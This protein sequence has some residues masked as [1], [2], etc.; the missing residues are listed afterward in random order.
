MTAKTVLIFTVIVAVIAVLAIVMNIRA[1]VKGK[2][3]FTK[4]RTVGT[5]L[6]SV[7]LIIVVA[8]NTAIY[9]FN[10]IIDIYF[11]KINMDSPEIKQARDDAKNLTEE[12]ESEGIVLLKNENNALPIQGKINLFGYSSLSVAYG[13]TG[14]GAGDES[15][16]ID[17]YTG[18]Q[19][20]GFETNDELKSFYEERLTEKTGT[21]IFHLTGGDYNNYEPSA[22]EFTDDIINNA[23]NF[24][25][26]AVVVFSRSGGEGGD[27]PTDMDGKEGGTAGKHYLELTDNERAMLDIAEENFD[28]VVVL[29]NSGNPM[30]LGFLE[31]EQIDAALWVGNPGSTG[32]NAIGSVLCGDTNPSGRLADTYAY[33]VTANPAY[34]NSGDFEYPN[35]DSIVQTQWFELEHYLYLDY[36]ENIYVG[37]R[38]YETRWVDNETGKCDEVAYHKAVQYPFGY[39]LSYTDFTQKIT[40]FE[41][42]GTTVKMDVTVTNTGDVSGKDV[43][44]IY[45]TAPYYVGGIE[46]AHV[47]LIDYGKTQV[48]EPGKSETVSFE[49]PVEDLASY[50]W[51]GIK[52]DGGAYVLEAGNYEIKVMNNAHDVLDSKNFDVKEDIIY[53]EANDG[54]RG[55]DVT[56]A[57]NHFDN[58]SNGNSITYVSRADWEG[59]DVT[60]RPEWKDASEEIIDALENPK[61]PVNDSD[62]PI[63]FAKNGLT[64]DD[65]KGLDYDDP[66]WEKLLEQLSVD[67]MVQ[68]TG[69]GGFATAEVSSVGKYKTMD[70][71]GPAGINGLVN[72]A[73]GIQYTSAVTLA[74]T[75]NQELAQRLGESMSNEAKEYGVSGLYAPAMNIHRTAFGGRNFEYYSEDGVLAGKTAAGFA[76]GTAKNGIYCYIKHFALDNQ[77]TNRENVCVWTSEQAI[78]E[79]YLKAFEL[80]VKEGN[81]T[82]VMDA[83]SRIGTDWCGGSSAL[84]NDVLRNEWGFQ[85]MVITDYIGDNFKDADVA[86]FN[87]CDLMLSTLGEKVTDIVLDNNSGQQ[88][89]RK[90]CHNILYTIANSDAQELSKS[91]LS[92][93]V[94]IMGIADVLLLAVMF[95]GLYKVTWKKRK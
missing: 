49:I 22:D 68:L 52:A 11:N 19:N 15:S 81:A 17:L 5:I 37:Y 35:T 82:A 72:G 85:G 67:D 29:I 61:F 51:Q 13:G 74:S 94:Y 21:D 39:G 33:D 34:Y 78:R 24:S 45:E 62:E 25:N 43:V 23:K 95:F 36:Q 53:N 92:T 1:G 20:A 12:I 47:N 44:Q 27:L 6:L 76:R 91:G 93:W 59:T 65:M 40:G 18:L 88:A 26:T 56:E 9:K 55:S 63:T 3:T 50:D 41:N 89:L 84:N 66:Q 42:D 38:Y 75:W 16:N 64:V 46:K 10:N 71:D 80:A 69:F 7:L 2:G 32:C 57:I 58:V 54:K 60:E 30:E 4:K 86:I 83:D 77:E 87:G 8:A 79:V 73:S 90:A 31:E 14:S 48:L 70:T 28:K